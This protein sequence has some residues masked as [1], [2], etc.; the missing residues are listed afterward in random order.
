MSFALTG[1]TRLN[2]IV[3][4]PIAQVRSPAGVTAAFGSRGVDAILVPTEV[5]QKDLLLFLDVCTRMKNLDGVIV[6]VPHK[7]ACSKYC[8]SRTQRSDFLG[9]VSVMRRDGAG[10]HGDIMDGVGFVEAARRHGVNPSEG[11]A[12]LVGAGGAGSA[13]A[14][15]LVEAG[16]RELAIHDQDPT[17][18]DVLIQR[19]SALSGATITMGSPD[20]S[21]FDFVANATPAGMRPDDPL[22]VDVS[23]LSAATYVGCVITA[24][25]IPPLIAAA[26]SL[27]CTTGTGAEMYAA[28]QELMIDF[29]L[30]IPG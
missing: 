9:A 7:F 16:A 13:I 8:H 29:L 11:R 28:L 17:R 14:L 27:G 1:A 22:P 26:R 25:E 23:K 30:R 2:V 21:G 3:G 5:A 24:P 12:L 19:L 18:R 20:P 4:D 15:A 6:T 10:W